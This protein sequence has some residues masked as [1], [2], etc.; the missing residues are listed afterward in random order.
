MRISVVTVTRDAAATVAATL[1]SVLTQRGVD[2][3]SIV[4]DGGSADGT[5]DEVKAVAERYPGRV[6]WMSR[7]DTGVYQAINR[8]VAM[9]TG[10]VV[11]LMHAGDRFAAADILARVAAE[12]ASADVPFIYGDVRFVDQ[13]TGRVTRRYSS[14]RFAPRLL[15]NGFAPP[16]PSLYVAR[17]VIDR[18]GPYKEDYVISA[19]FE[20][21]VRLMLVNR[22]RGRYLPVEMVEM[23]TG[24]LSSRLYNRLWTNNVERLKALRS[25]GLKAS[26]LRL[27][28]RYF[29]V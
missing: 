6:K 1:E 9:A 13:S 25:N 4:V 16:H 27:I 5:V 26:P 22:L 21:F 28:K 23:S 14:R 8:G 3:E 7:E 18:V 12:F 19:D 29:Y 20:Y 10:D 11:G 15:L 2:V 17:G 24:G